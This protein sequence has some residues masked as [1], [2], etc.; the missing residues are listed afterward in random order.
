[1]ERT[2]FGSRHG[3]SPCDA[4][5]GIVKSAARRYVKSRRELIRNAQELFDFAKSNLTKKHDNTYRPRTLFYQ[6]KFDHP[7]HASE[8]SRGM[9]GTQKIHQVRAM[10]KHAVQGRS[11]ACYCHGC[12]VEATCESKAIIGEWHKRHNLGPEEPSRKFGQ[13]KHTSVHS[14]AVGKTKKKCRG[15]KQQTRSSGKKQGTNILCHR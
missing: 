11:L 5:G 10:G 14:K 6:E 2:Y 9:P 15:K 7:K 4:L 1:M 13:K 12:L 3:K 8:N